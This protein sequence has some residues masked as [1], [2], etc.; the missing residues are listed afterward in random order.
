MATIE[1][2]KRRRGT[3]F[4][5]SFYRNERFK[6]SLPSC[7]TQG[8]AREL[9][10]VIDEILAAQKRGCEP[11]VQDYL[12]RAP[13]LILRKLEKVG[14]IEVTA[15]ATLAERLEAYEAD[16]AS[17][18]KPSTVSSLVAI[19]KRL[20]P[21][22]DFSLTAEEITQDAA[23][24]AIAGATA[25]CAPAYS[26][27]IL[28][29]A[30]AFFSFAAPELSNPFNSIKLP[31]ARKIAGRDFNV[32]AEWS[33][34][35]LDA[36]PTQAWRAAFALWRF[37]GLRFREAFRVQWTDVLFEKRRLVVHSDK[38]ERYGKGIRV[39]PLFPELEKELGARFLEETPEVVPS[40]SETKARRDLETII[41]RAGFTPW[42]R[43][44][45]NLRA[46]RE[47]ELVAAGFP[48][49]V[50]ADWLG[51]TSSVQSRYYLRV[52]DSYFDAATRPESMGGFL[53][54]N[55]GENDKNESILAPSRT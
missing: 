52:L 43:L 15:R 54:E 4:V 42:T 21:N 50:V 37:G 20:R 6:I 39:I 14:L 29:A 31:P 28:T 32:P 34:G 36:C 40:I 23:R 10:A 30:R 18:L 2:I 33:A 55:M 9:A 5:V 16:A 45:Q 26:R 47:N 35:I 44:F 12:D 13:E 3:A 51:H 53:G 41:A 38:T 8:D 17:R 19:F 24:R 46:T 7:F 48:A 1:K 27:Q 49:H 25:G 11:R 22:L